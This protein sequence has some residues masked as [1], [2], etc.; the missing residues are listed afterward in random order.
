MFLSS[1]QIDQGF[2]EAKNIPLLW[3]APHTDYTEGIIRADVVDLVPHNA[4]Y[5]ISPLPF[6]C[7][8]MAWESLVIVTFYVLKVPIRYVNENTII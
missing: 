7:Y 6:G 2:P 1:Y 4:F 3:W 8:Q 5:L